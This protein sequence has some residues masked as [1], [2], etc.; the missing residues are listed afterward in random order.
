MTP[1]D[2]KLAEYFVDTLVTAGRELTEWETKFVTSVEMQL[3][4]RHFISDKQFQILERI[5]TDRTP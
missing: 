3:L 5:Y 1:E 2:L 4:E